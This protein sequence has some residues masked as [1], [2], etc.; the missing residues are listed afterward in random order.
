M[1]IY[2]AG[3][4]DSDHRSLMVHVKK[5]VEQLINKETDTIY[6][7][8]ELK[9]ENAWDLTQ[10]AWSCEV[11]THDCKAMEDCDFAILIS[12]GRESSAGTNWEQGYLYAQGKKI[13]VLQVTD[14]PTSLMTYVGCFNFYNVSENQQELAGAIKFIL[15]NWNQPHIH[16]SA[17]RTVL[18]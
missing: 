17:C 9:I 8:F 10:E 14:K 7:P 5:T 1:H 11:F 3:P 13:F 12:Y 4:C 2:L 18:T 15:Q 16:K 6:C